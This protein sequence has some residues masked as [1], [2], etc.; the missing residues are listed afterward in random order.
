MEL[1]IGSRVVLLRNM[2][3][4]HGGSVGYVCNVYRD[5]DNPSKQGVQVIFSGGGFDG[6]SQREQ[7]LY[8]EHRGDD[9]RYSTYNFKNVLQVEKDFRNGLWKFYE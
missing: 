1:T 5:F 4:E 2:L 8:L 7:E 6:F 3:G 9:P